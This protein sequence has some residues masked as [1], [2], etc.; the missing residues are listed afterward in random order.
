MKAI[1]NYDDVQELQKLTGLSSEILPGTG[2]G[3]APNFS[4]GVVEGALVLIR[5][6]RV[7]IVQWIDVSP[8]RLAFG[9]PP[10]RRRGGF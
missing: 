6:W 4:L 5:F 1:A 7:S 10:P 3:T 8:L 9:D 2:R